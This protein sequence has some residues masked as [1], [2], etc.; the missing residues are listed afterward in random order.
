MARP[1]DPI[2]TTKFPVEYLR[3]EG[4]VI[5]SGVSYLFKVFRNLSAVKTTAYS[6]V[7]KHDNSVPDKKEYADAVEGIREAFKGTV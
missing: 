7:R 6:I 5:V 3:A 1:N 2:P 4:E